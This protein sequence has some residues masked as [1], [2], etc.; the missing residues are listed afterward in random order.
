MIEVFLLVLAVL[1]ASNALVLVGLGLW[2]RRNY[3][4][5]SLEIIE[6]EKGP[7]Y[8]VLEGPHA[9]V[10]WPVGTATFAPGDRVE[11]HLHVPSGTIGTHVPLL[12]RW[13]MAA[14]FAV[15]AVVL[16]WSS[17]G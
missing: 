2:H 14:G 4:P 13:V 1:A 16:F 8:R 11:G 10:T 3:V 7:D 12:D 15:V 5:V 9:G 17:S 6:G